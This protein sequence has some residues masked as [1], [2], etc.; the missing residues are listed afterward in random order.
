MRRAACL[1][2]VLTLLFPAC[3]S[4]CLWDSDTLEQER[5]RFPEAHQLIVGD[6]V[7]H[8]EAYYRWRIEDRL[9]KPI[10]ARMPMDYDDVAV[11]Y[12]KLG[13]QDKAIET[14]HEKIRRFSSQS[15]YESEANLGTFLI[16]AGRLEE[17]LVHIDK[18][19]EINPDA[20]FGREIYQK[21]LVEYVLLRRADGDEGLPLA[22]SDGENFVTFLRDRLAWKPESEMAEK[23]KALTGVLG[24]M[25]FG[26]YDSPILLE[27]LG[28]LLMSQGRDANQLAAQ[29]YLRASAM[30]DDRDAAAAYFSKAGQALESQ[31]NMKLKTL[32][33]ELTE[34]VHKANEKFAQIQSDEQ[35]WAA[36]GEDLDQKFA[37][38]YYEQPLLRS[39]SLGV[40]SLGQWLGQYAW[41]AV[42]VL[43]VT[44]AIW[45]MIRWLK[46][47]LSA[48]QGNSSN[49]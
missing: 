7:R 5:Y 47:D 37:S 35:A 29:A 38:K 28:D 46:A 3:C 12:D 34:S 22:T 17:G 24:M 8:S 13:Q 31:R 15:V 42:F 40:V 48:A 23:K 11:A 9:A 41:A 44:A 1:F 26:H 10:D 21:L 36:A 14:I 39:A 6:F 25:R 32:Q 19:I 49:S 30:A 2:V 45:G 16:H 4:A 27:A 20:H 18:A 33:K 43:V